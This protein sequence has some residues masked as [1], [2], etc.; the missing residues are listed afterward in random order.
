M[1][2][3]ETVFVLRQDLTPQQVEDIFKDFKKIISDGNGKLLKEENWG[4]RSLAY[5]I[6]KNKKGHYVLLE[7]EAPAAA[8][9]EFERKLGLNENVLRF[10]TVKLD[11]P[12]EGP[13]PM[14]SQKDVKDERK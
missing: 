1:A 7:T 10:M 2:F 11:K 14:L 4:L 6:K 9:T 8:I 3:Y 13:S 12:S 5:K